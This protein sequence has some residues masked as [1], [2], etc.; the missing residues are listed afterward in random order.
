MLNEGPLSVSEG[1]GFIVCVVGSG[2]SR[3]GAG[4]QVSLC[5][6][7]CFFPNPEGWKVRIRIGG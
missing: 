1:G 3:P 4:E 6:T 2:T 7:G 5:S